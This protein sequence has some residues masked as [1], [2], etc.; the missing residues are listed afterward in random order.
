MALVVNWRADGQGGVS[1]G[2]HTDRF[3]K[4]GGRWKCLERVSDIDSDWPAQLFQPYA[5]RADELF[6]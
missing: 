4:R 2:I 3:E 1:T 6:R 5:D